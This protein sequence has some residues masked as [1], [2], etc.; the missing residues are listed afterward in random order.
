MKKSAI[1]LGILI[2]V[3]AASLSAQPVISE[4]QDIAI[5]ALGYYGWN[6]PYQSLGSIDGEIQK[7][8]ANLGR[9]TILGMSQ[10]LSPGGLEQFIATMRQTKQSGFVLPE[11]FQ[12]G[13]AFLTEQEFNRLVGAFVVVV[14]VVVEFN[15]WWD[16]K[17]LKFRTEIKTTISFIEAASGS[18]LAIKT[19]NSSGSD[20]NNEYQSISAA[21]ASIPMQ[22]QYEIRSIP[23]FQIST[24]ILTVNGSTARLQMGS[25]MGIMKGD[26]YA[27]VEK[28]SVEGFD[29]SR[30][31]G[32]IVIKDVGREV[33]SGQVLYASV[34]L[35]KDTQLQEIPR[36]GLDLDF[37][38]HI[39][40]TQVLPGL[41]VTASRGFYALRPFAAA[42]IPLGLI[43]SFY[44]VSI[45]P[46]NVLLGL[47]YVVNAGRLSV[48]PSAAAG[49]SY[50]HV[51]SGTINTDTDVLSH[52]GF[53]LG[54]RLAYLFGRN[55]RI[56]LD[57]GLE[58]W[59]SLSRLYILRDPS[60]GGLMMGVGLTLKL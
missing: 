44:T 55:A 11:K 37:Y 8:F 15:S 34:E 32:L 14:P 5:F 18:L 53:Q 38:L 9:F 13:E 41:R 7:V 31:A 1:A 16:S 28:R 17:N 19:L 20:A 59:S 57:F 26:E 24:R 46:V 42:Q 21:I 60:Y 25:N 3:A 56:F 33:S 52:I 51:T 54:G 10:R 45:F 40:G 12:F 35:A 4:K 36:L 29:D 23:Q 27:I 49:L 6:L 50:Y 39:L 58:G 48:A 47:E 22:L 30:E 43:S 2:V